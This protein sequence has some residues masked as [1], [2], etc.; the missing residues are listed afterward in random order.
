MIGSRLGER[1]AVFGNAAYLAE[2]PIMG[3]LRRGIG[4]VHRRIACGG[5]QHCSRI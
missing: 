5:I 3:V 4:G 2:R 1:M